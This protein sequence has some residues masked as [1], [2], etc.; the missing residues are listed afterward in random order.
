MNFSIQH[1][2]VSLLMNEN[3]APDV[4]VDVETILNKLV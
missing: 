4:R 2:S 1:T 3:A